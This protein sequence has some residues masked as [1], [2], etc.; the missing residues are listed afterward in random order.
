M[1]QAFFLI[2]LGLPVFAFAQSG[3]SLNWQKLALEERLERRYNNSLSAVLKDNQYLIDVGVEVDEP[4]AP[5]LGNGKPAGPRVSDIKL[6][7]SRGDFIA[8]S[9]MGL[10][11]PVL[12]KF[13]D[14]DKQKLLN[15][16]KF[17]ETYDLFKS[18]T[19]VKVTVFLSD[20]LPPELAEI[21]KNVIGG[22]RLAISGIKPDVQ[23]ETMGLE[24]TAPKLPEKPVEKPKAEEVKPKKKEVVEPKEPKIWTKDWL[25]WASRWGNAVGLLLCTIIFSILAFSIFRQW[26]D[27]MEK[28]NAKNLEKEEKSENSEE[29]LA[30]GEQPQDVQED[31]VQSRHGLERF[32]QCLNQ[33]PDEAVNIIR[34]W[35]TEGTPES[36]LNLRTIAQQ[37][38]REEM[39]V[40]LS[41]L[42]QDQRDRWNSFLGQHLEEA[43]M[44]KASKVIFQDVVKAMLVPSR[45]KDGELQNLVLELDMDRTLEFLNQH[46]NFVGMMLNILNPSTVSKLISQADEK[47]VDKWLV[48]GAGFDFNSME[49]R[50]PELKNALR[51]F[52]KATAPSPFLQR[53]VEMIPSASPEREKTLYKA[54]SSAGGTPLI[55]ELA[56]QNLPYDLIMRLPIPVLREAFQSLPVAKRIEVVITK[57][58]SERQHLMNALADANTPARDMMEMELSNLSNDTARISQIQTRSEETW[59]EFVKTVRHFLRSNTSGQ[60]QVKTLVNEWCKQYGA[61]LKVVNGG[62]AA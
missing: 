34:S 15:L 10:E 25:E 48:D 29:Q 55:A 5:N 41:G 4:I 43:E 60:A 8:F 32:Q 37:S 49:A 38:T 46:D 36:I 40:L 62:K 50:L 1:K 17:N 61:G 21:A 45:I 3:N 47:K 14:E 24:Y 42:L 31:D 16:Y 26:K 39:Q 6:E 59:M 19:A 33:H 7:E 27:L 9:K 58:S 23:F 56:S 57:N 44:L 2:L 28:L 35:I 51:M 53:L 22:T 12:D 54:L 52:S 11:V 20:K 13:Y 30:D 18:I